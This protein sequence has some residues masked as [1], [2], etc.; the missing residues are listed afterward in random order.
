MLDKPFTFTSYLVIGLLIAFLPIVAQYRR[1]PAVRR[2]QLIWGDS[3]TGAGHNVW[4]WLYRHDWIMGCSCGLIIGTTLP[5]WRAIKSGFSLGEII[6]YGII[7]TACLLALGREASADDGRR[8]NPTS[9]WAVIAFAGVVAVVMSFTTGVL[10]TPEIK[11]TAWHHWGAY[12]GPAELALSGARIFYDFPAQYGFGPTLLIASACDSNC[13]IAMYFIAGGAA[14]AFA[15]LGFFIISGLPVRTLAALAVIVG[16]TAVGCLLW[17]AYPPLVSSALVAPSTAGLR[18][19]PALALVVMMMWS[20][21]EAKLQPHWTKFGFAVFAVGALWSPESL[22]M[23]SFVWGPYYCLRRMAGVSPHRLMHVLFGS[24]AMLSF[25][26]ITILAAFLVL[27]RWRFGVSPTL[28]A[29]LAYMLYPPGPMPINPTGPVWF[30]VTALALGAWSSRGLFVQGGNS[31]AF[32]RSLLLILLSYASFSYALGR[33]HD[34]N[35]LN[36]IPYSTLII[37]SV[38]MSQVPVFLRAIAAGMLASLLGLS[39]LFGWSAWSETVAGGRLF[40]FKPQE[41]VAS[42]SYENPETAAILALRCVPGACSPADAS[43]ALSQIRET[44][45]DPAMV[46]DQAFLS[47]PATSTTAWSAMHEPANYYFLPREWRQ[48]FL[49]RTAFQLHR[50]GWLVVQKSLPARWIDDF[51]SAYSIA[52]DLNF[53]TYRALHFVPRP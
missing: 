6:A 1:A 12:I 28:N 32:R 44:S 7:I 16:A 42:L 2:V 29:Y 22:F 27:Y 4:R 17:V 49:Q 30:C 11:I 14:L 19:L 48:T 34:N 26:V 45:T 10:S 15:L 20:E 13:W 3:P 40:E 5:W 8:V 38:V 39:S 51:Q 37:S 33:S 31:G 46:L 50:G 25:A 47:L 23:S 9:K 53:G 36:I 52:E 41:F 35:F 18:F 24:V 43:R 21:G